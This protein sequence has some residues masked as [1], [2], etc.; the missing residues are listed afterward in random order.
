MNN[1]KQRYAKQCKVKTVTF[2]KCDT[3]LLEFANTINFQKEVKRFLRK[4]KQSKDN[5]LKL[6]GE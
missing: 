2:Y 5:Y 1:A 3:E 6:K 4:Q